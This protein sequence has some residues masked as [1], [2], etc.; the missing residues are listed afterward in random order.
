MNNKL[1]VCCTRYFHKSVIE[2]NLKFSNI[3]QAIATRL[4]IKPKFQ[5]PLSGNTSNWLCLRAKGLLKRYH[6]VS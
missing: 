6:G 3:M 2:P 5:Q 1:Q 4:I